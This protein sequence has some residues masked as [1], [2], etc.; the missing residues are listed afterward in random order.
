MINTAYTGPES[1]TSS[2]CAYDCSAGEVST[3]KADGLEQKSNLF[4]ISGQKR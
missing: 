3:I 4:F 2:A 1:F